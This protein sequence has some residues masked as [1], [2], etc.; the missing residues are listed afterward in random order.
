MNF[1]ESCEVALDKMNE[2]LLDIV[3]SRQI[4][5]LQT[6]PIESPELIDMP[7]VRSAQSA[8]NASQDLEEGLRILVSFCRYS[9]KQKPRA[10]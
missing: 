8:G 9:L 4:F 3:R 10:Q 5:D 2:E 1:T 7:V 6:L